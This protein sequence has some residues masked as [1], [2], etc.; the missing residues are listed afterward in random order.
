MITIDPTL[1][2]GSHLTA[3]MV[4]RELVL[5]DDVHHAPT[6]LVCLE[7]TMNGEVFPFSEME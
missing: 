6:G 3:E 2:E 7:N 5:D 1:H 4:R